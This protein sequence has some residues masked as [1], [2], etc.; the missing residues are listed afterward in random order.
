MKELFQIFL[1]VF[2][3]YFVECENG[4][5]HSILYYLLLYEF[6][7]GY[8]VPVCLTI[9]ELPFIYCMYGLYSHLVVVVDSEQ[10]LCDND[11]VLMGFQPIILRFLCSL[12]TKDV[13]F[14][15][16]GFFKTI[17]LPFGH[18]LGK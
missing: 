1:C 3:L 9:R 2:I 15:T 7:G 13:I 18:I 10:S 14:Y 8:A 11:E 4:V 16:K 12:L 5:L 17:W 6:Q